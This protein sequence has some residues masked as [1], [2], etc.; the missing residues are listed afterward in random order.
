MVR[1]VRRN[2]IYKLPGLFTSTSSRAGRACPERAGCSQSAN[3][4]LRDAIGT[5][6]LCLRGTLRETLHG[7]TP[8]V[9]CERR[10]ATEAH[11]LRLRA[12]AAG[13]LFHL[14]CQSEQLVSMANPGP[15]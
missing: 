7:L 14:W 4:R 6:Q 8:L 13:V 5:R 9:G 11:A 10:R 12:S 15:M 2:A 1:L 3:G